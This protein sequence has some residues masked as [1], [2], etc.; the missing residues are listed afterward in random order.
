MTEPDGGCELKP[1]A[2]Q[3]VKEK[4]KKKKKKK[5]SNSNNDMVHGKNSLIKAK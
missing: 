5:K 4:K 3:G 2:P 1:H